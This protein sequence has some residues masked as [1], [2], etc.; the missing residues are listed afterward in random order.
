MASASSKESLWFHYPYK[1]VYTFAVLITLPLRL[2]LILLY[3]IPSPLRQHPKWTYR[4][5][6]GLEIF[7]IWW[8][9]AAAVRYYTS[10]SL[11]P[12]SLKERFIIMQPPHTHHAH[13]SIYRG[14]ARDTIERPISTVQ[15]MPVGA[16]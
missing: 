4:Q 3:Y 13:R 5:A 7:L 1:I 6:I 14:I 11:E 15:P 16:V 8:K 2:L 9:Y 12:G 10:K